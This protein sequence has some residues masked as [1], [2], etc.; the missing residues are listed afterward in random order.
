MGD[1][2]E[3][4]EVTAILQLMAED[5]FDVLNWARRLGLKRDAQIEQTAAAFRKSLSDAGMAI[6]VKEPSNG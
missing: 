5:A 3:A 1:Q 2:P 6:T 4:P